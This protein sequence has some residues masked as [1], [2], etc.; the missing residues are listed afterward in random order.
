MSSKKQT[1]WVMIGACLGAMGVG[2]GAFGAHALNDI[3]TDH[4]K[5]VYDTASKYMLIHA[6]LI[7]AVGV[8]STKNIPKS[9]FYSFVVGACIFSGSLWILAITQIKWLGAITPL[10]GVLLIGG[11][12]RLAWWGKNADSAPS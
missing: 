1:I 4:Y 3:M 5:D 9:V 12:L 11:W 6:V 7:T 2:M 8:N 10:G